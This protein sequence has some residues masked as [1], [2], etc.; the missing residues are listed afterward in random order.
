VNDWAITTVLFT[1]TLYGCALVIKQLG[2][3]GR[4]EGNR[5]WLAYAALVVVLYG[6]TQWRCVTDLISPTG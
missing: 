4:L 3:A 1:L 2:N 6:V 5:K